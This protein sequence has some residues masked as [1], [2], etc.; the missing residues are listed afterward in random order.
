MALVADANCVV[1]ACLAADGFVMFGSQE[2]L[3]PDLM[4]WEAASTLHEYLWRIDAARRTPDMAGLAREDVLGAFRRL[5]E[6]PIERVPLDAALLHEAWRVADRCGFARL[7]DAAYV[8][9]AR[10]RGATLVTLDARLHGSPAA[11][12]VRI[13]G[14]LELV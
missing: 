3:A 9:L 7:Y 10:A 5:R 4:W 14:P 8:A 13:V 11:A 1:A 2:L 6:A 12:L